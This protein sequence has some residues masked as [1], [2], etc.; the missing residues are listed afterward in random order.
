[1]AGIFEK[2]SPA[3]ARAARGT[4]L[5]FEFVPGDLPHHLVGEL[6]AQ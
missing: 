2:R 6:A 1:M 5:A 3:A 4:G